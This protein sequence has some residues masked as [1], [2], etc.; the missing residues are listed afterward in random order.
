MAGAALLGPGENATRV[1]V[2][3]RD[4]QAQLGQAHPMPGRARTQVGGAD[5]G[6]VLV[7]DPQPRAGRADGAATVPPS[8]AEQR[9]RVPGARPPRRRPAVAPTA[10]LLQLSE[11]PA[12]PATVE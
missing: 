3:Q 1:P 10:G 9:L 8:Q 12:G 2:A 6:P 5:R 7:E 4:P 11:G